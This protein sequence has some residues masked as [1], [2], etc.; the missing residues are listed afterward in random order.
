MISKRKC[1]NAIRAL[2]MDAVQCANSGHPGMPMGMA[3]IA[4]VLWRDF[5]KFNPANPNWPNRDRFVLS[6]GHGA[7][8]LYAVLH[9]TGYKISIN[10]IKQF[11]QLH[12]NTPGH[13][14]HGET[15]GVETTTGPL[16][17]GLAN[18]VGMAIAEQIMAKHFNREGY[19][20]VDHHTYVFAGDGDL[21]EGISH[22]VCSLA[23][24]LGLGKLIVIYDDNG[25]SIDG[26][27][28]GWFTDDTPKRFEAYHWHVIAKVDGHDFEAIKA[29][30]A[31]AK[32]EMN[33]PTLI[34][35]QTKIGYGAPTL[36][37][38]ADTHGSPLGEE[39]ISLARKVLDWP[40]PSFEIPEEVYAA[41][42]AV[43]K[44]Q[45]LENDWNKR[46]SKYESQFPDLAAEFLRRMHGYLPRDWTSKM[47]PFIKECLEF[48]KDE[49]TRKSSQR[50]LNV[51]GPLLPELI[52]GSA[53]LTVSNNTSWSGST[54]LS[55]ENRDGNYIEYGVR[56]F[57]MS[58]MMN[59]MALHS[60]FIP[61][62]GTFLT[63]V[64]Y[65]RNAVRLAALMRQRVIFVYTHDSIGLGEDGPTHQPIEHASMLRVTP[66]V[67]VWR[68]CDLMETA[69]AWIQAIENKGPSCLLLTRQN[70]M[71]QPHSENS[72]ENIKRG[73]YILYQGH[74]DQ[75]HLDGIYIATGSE[76]EIA[77]GAA[78]HLAQEGLNIR[79]V[80]MPCCEIFKQQNQNYR[81]SVL[82][83]KIT[84]RVAIEAGAPDYWHQFVGLHGKIIGLD[85][86]GMSAPAKKV[87][88]TLGF[89]VENA[90]RL[91]LE[92][93]ANTSEKMMGKR[94]LARHSRGE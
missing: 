6:N 44:G 7:M 24:T 72:I 64:D 83:S 88:E 40:Y 53:D 73:G 67:H 47:V 87:F 79:V 9:L 37:G 80:S 27:V 81:E 45:I 18:A 93:L 30:I 92:L 94:V 49:A 42:S 8:L 89:T 26:D 70:V 31:T 34:C 52:G 17:Q 3:D 35:C 38:T 62:G 33:K 90:K 2:A 55:K 78:K 11:R 10:D 32:Q 68:P 76:V 77:I 82:P 12:S 74:N 71:Q 69:I 58:A 13:P 29:A 85:R 75:D 36:G 43:T 48:N 19:D 39:E 25:I 57:G 14:E 56:E 21:M 84:A 22:E 5:L 51:L 50:C 86:F 15:T 20:I 28:K 1:A 91:M 61:Y 46:F 54:I 4:E 63:F 65:A 66:G 41:W 60:G 23:G 59:G 16:G